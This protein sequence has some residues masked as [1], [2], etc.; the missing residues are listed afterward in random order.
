MSY[1]RQ[2]YWEQSITKK[3]TL[4]QTEKKNVSSVGLFKIIDIHNQLEAT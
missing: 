1:H 2:G 4:I 3:K